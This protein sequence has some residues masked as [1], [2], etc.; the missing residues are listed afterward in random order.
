MTT[1]VKPIPEGYHS[2]TPY[3]S[4]K[5]A[6]KAIEFYKKVFNAKEIGRLKTPDGKIGHC[7]LQIG[8]SRIMMAEEISGMGGKSPQTLGGSPIG[9]CL[10]VENADEVYKRALAAGAKVDKNMEMKDQFYGDRSGTVTDPFGYSWTIGT[11]V[12]DVPY[13]KMQ[14]RYEDAISKMHSV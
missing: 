6:E 7:E 5:N 8:D 11:H 14:T 4:I 2:L 12:E 10:Y 3:L 1:K 9:L 13:D